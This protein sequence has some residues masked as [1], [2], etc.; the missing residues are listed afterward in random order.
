MSHSGN[1]ADGY[2]NDLDSEGYL[3]R[4]VECGDVGVEDIPKSGDDQN[5]KCWPRNASKR[6]CSS[7]EG[8]GVG[9]SKFWNKTPEHNL[10]TYP[11]GCG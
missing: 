9:F 10:P 8:F 7:G 6:L 5:C 4:R 11:N 3:V 2:K 1:G